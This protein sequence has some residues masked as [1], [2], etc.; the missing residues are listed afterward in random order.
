MEIFI[1]GSLHLLDDY[2][3]DKEITEQE[4]EQGKFF[5]RN[6]FNKDINYVIKESNEFYGQ[7]IKLVALAYRYPLCPS[8]LEYLMEEF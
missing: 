1:K 6:I 3:K 8:S 7:L 5:V 4:I 2:F